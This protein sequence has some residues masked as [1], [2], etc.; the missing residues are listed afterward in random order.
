MLLSLFLCKRPVSSRIV[1][2]R[3]SGFKSWVS[4]SLIG[5]YDIS[6]DHYLKYMSLLFIFQSSQCRKLMEE[7]IVL[8]ENI[9]IIYSLI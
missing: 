9:I 5:Q 6:I 7:V 8:I 2:A 3:G 4:L 1:N